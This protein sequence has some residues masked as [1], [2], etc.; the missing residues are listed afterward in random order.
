MRIA[1]YLRTSLIEWPGK[2]SS[3]IF[4]PGCNFACPFC[5]NA[6]LVRNKGTQE[7]SE[8]SVLED[9]KKR[10]KWIDG[11]VITGGEPTLQPDLPEFI[12]KV[13]KLGFEIMLETN[14]SLPQ[15]LQKTLPLLDYLSLDFKT[16]FEDYSKVVR[17]K[18]FDVRDWQKSLRLIIAAQIPFEIRTTVVPTIHNQQVL[19]AMAQELSKQ[20]ACS[21]W[22]WQSFVPQNCLD[23]SFL[24][25]KPHPVTELETLARQAKNFYSEIKIK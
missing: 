14:G 21:T 23:K 19:V 7:I 16:R 11:V 9:L 6:D 15:N 2:I 10:K 25:I 5:H 17:N 8:Q 20:L 3:V 12:A 13:K 18:N 1:G 24:K 22:F 4:T